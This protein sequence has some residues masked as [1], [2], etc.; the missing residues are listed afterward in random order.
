MNTQDGARHR[1]KA[2]RLAGKIPARD[3]QAKKDGEKENPKTDGQV[4]MSG[5]QEIS[6][7]MKVRT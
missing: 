5:Q 4:Y 7:N 3:L 1:R 6:S 2:A